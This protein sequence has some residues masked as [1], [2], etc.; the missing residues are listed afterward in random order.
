MEFREFIS[1]S[2]RKAMGGVGGTKVK[3]GSLYLI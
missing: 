1:N 3:K 2:Q